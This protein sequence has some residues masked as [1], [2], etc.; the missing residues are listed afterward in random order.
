MN[1]SSNTAACHPEPLNHF[2]INVNPRQRCQYYD[3]SSDKY[4]HDWP[5]SLTPSWFFAPFAASADFLTAASTVIA[6]VAIHVAKEEKNSD[7]EVNTK[8]LRILNCI[9]LQINCTVSLQTFHSRF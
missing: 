3:R 7:A 2:N 6:T 1:S 5:V 8:L 4:R 9:F